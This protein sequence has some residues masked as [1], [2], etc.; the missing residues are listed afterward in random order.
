MAKE[1]RVHLTAAQKSR[2][3]VAV[4]KNRGRL[5]TPSR[6]E[7]ADPGDAGALPESTDVECSGAKLTESGK[8]RPTSVIP[9]P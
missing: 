3:G 9:L 4:N 2:I 8:R 1:V 5:P 7:S 6:K